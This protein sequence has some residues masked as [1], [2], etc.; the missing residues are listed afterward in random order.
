MS[1]RVRVRKLNYDC[2]HIQ[3]PRIGSIFDSGHCTANLIAM[4]IHIHMYVDFHLSTTD[5]WLDI[6]LCTYATVR[7]V[8]ERFVVTQSVLL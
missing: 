6:K 3:W 2:G 8:V 7:A 5:S 4:E 1:V